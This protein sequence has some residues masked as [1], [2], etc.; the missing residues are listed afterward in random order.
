MEIMRLR[1]RVSRGIGW[2]GR[3]WDRVVEAHRDEVPDLGAYRRGTLNVV[4]VEP[5]C[6]PG[7]EAF[8]RRAHERGLGLG[9]E[10]SVGADFLACGNY[11]HPDI[12]VRS[13]G[14]KE[15]EGRL[16]VPGIPKDRWRD[17]TSAWEGPR[18]V[19]RIEVISKAHLR[20]ILG[21]GPDEEAEVEVE[22]VVSDR[23]PSG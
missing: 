12:R 23:P 5:W 3:E 16:Y 4:L 11:I 9:E 18:E 8:R 1:G 2:A 20:T 13:I 10:P 14:G 22:L 15:V 21:L 17:D 7:D 19:R 6:L